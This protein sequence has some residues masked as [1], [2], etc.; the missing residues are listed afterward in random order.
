MSRVVNLG[1]E[2]YA[3]VGMIDAEDVHETAGR[4][5]VSAQPICK[6]V[7]AETFPFTTAAEIA[8][9]EPEVTPWYVPGFVAPKTVTEFDGKLKQSGKTTLIGHMVRAIV[10]GSPFLGRPTRQ[11]AVVWLT[12]ERPA[13]FRETLKRANLLDRTDVHVLHWHEVRGIPWPAVCAS[14]VAKADNVGAGVLIVDTIGQWAGLRGDAE[15]NNGDQ[16]AAAE[17]LQAAAAQGLACVVARHERKGGG[18]VGESGRGGSAFS[19]AVDIVV[20][21]RRAEGKTKPTVRVLHALSRFSE[22]PES[23]V[24]DL[25]TDGYIALGSAGTV[26]VLEAERALLDRFPT[27]EAAALTLTDLIDGAQPRIPRTVAQRALD[28]LTEA[29]AVSR[30]GSGK[31][32]DAYRY[33]KA[34][35]VSAQ[36]QIPIQGRNSTGHSEQPS[37]RTADDDRF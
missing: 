27:T 18:E 13:S 26:A 8:A 16:M 9:S 32:K 4:H 3:D 22:T 12:E 17:P 21:I 34:I 20:S 24:I 23:L 25:T 15:N 28:K 19:G 10:T 33:F 14:S 6:R 5:S 30:L 37:N 29:G 2:D 36:T 35:D 31:K 7:R 1:R 11:T